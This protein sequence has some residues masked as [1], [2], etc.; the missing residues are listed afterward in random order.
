MYNCVENIVLQTGK[1][2]N[3]DT[4]LVGISITDNA[5]ILFQV[6]VAKKSY[7]FKRLHINIQSH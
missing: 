7:H 6:D 4:L 2:S 3:A 1:Y 5:V